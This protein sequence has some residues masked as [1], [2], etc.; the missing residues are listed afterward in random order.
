MGFL[1]PDSGEI[2]VAG[3]NIAGYTEEQ[4]QVVRKKVT[5]VFQNGALFD[6]LTVGENVALSPC[7]ERGRTDRRSDHPDRQ[8]PVGDGRCSRHGRPAA[9]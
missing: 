1:K 6:S 7:R 8:R 4:M 9:F 3:E 2:L 5:M